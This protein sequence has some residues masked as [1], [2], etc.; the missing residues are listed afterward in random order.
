MDKNTSDK[1]SDWNKPFKV[2]SGGRAETNQT[3]ER[4]EMHQRTQMTENQGGLV[5]KGRL[6]ERMLEGSGWK[7]RRTVAVREAEHGTGKAALVLWVTLFG[8]FRDGQNA[9]R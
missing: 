4:E 3:Q 9:A 8:C 2:R 5:E 7:T 1:A 6:L